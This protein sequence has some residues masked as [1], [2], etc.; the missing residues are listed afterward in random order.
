MSLTI[1]PKN[2]AAA[3]SVE[4][5]RLSRELEGEGQPETD[6]VVAVIRLVPVPVRRAAVDRVVEVAAAA[7]DTVNTLRQWTFST[8][9]TEWPD[10]YLY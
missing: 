1:T 8:K 6:V 2:R 5:I 7:K 3:C 4:A 10:I 9:D